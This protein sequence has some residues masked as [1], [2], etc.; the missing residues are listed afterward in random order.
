M[1]FTVKEVH[2]KSYACVGGGRRLGAWGSNSG[3]WASVNLGFSS[4]TTQR[5]GYQDCESPLGWG[6]PR[7]DL[8]DGRPHEAALSASIFG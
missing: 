4:Q 1:G 3:S 8:G 5:E 2:C 7:D 6:N